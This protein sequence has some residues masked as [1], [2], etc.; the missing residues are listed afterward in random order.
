MTTEEFYKT[1]YPIG[2]PLTVLIRQ[3]GKEPVI[4]QGIIHK[5]LLRTE[6]EQA[7]I[8]AKH[9]LKSENGKTKCTTA[10]KHLAWSKKCKQQI[11]WELMAKNIIASDYEYFAIRILIH[12]SFNKKGQILGTI[13]DVSNSIKGVEDMLEDVFYE[14]DKVVMFSQSEY[15]GEVQPYDEFGKPLLTLEVYSV[16]IKE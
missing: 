4:K 7:S 1:I 10:W 12:N 14:N 13:Q 5:L 9:V 6:I 2:K 16:R 11:G 8:N 3:K 15:S